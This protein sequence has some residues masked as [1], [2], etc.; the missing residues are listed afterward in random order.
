MPNTPCS[1]RGPGVAAQLVAGTALALVLGEG[2][3]RVWDGGAMPQVSRFERVGE[4]ARVAL[5]P[6][7][8][9]R[10]RGREAY[11]V[12]TD[13]LGLRTCGAL[14]DGGGG[15]I[16]AGDS[17]V[18]G[19]GVADEAT[20]CVHARG[21]GL[22]VWSAGV[23]GHGLADALEHASTLLA[24]LG[25]TGV[26]AVVNDA[27][28][29]TEAGRP[30]IARCG[31]AGGWLVRPEDEH[32]ARG[33]FL[34]SPLARS[35]LLV[36]AA[37]VALRDPARDPR[38]QRVQDSPWGLPA[39]GR[40]ERAARLAADIHAFRDAHPDV[41]L[42][43]VRLP[44][45]FATSRARAEA[46]LPAGALDGILPAPWEDPAP[47]RLLEAALGDVPV[48]DAAPAVASPSDYLPYDYHLSE[49]GHAAFA[50]VLVDALR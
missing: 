43:V 19:L 26:V 13:A 30:A 34:R 16:V 36:Y 47:F 1:D 38:L 12:T 8:A 5:A 6:N 10:L 4:P 40:P 31:V 28:D 33:A 50:R 48:L 35:H 27:N 29:W 25:A 49:A 44:V 45:D 41:A 42:H 24:P 37:Q 9:L 21:A 32:G 15:W 20:W 23:P 46:E 7:V 22:R 39:D 2:V 3:V 11:T 18:L 14:P 17:Q